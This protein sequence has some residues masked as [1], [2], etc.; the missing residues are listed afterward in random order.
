MNGIKRAALTIRSK[1]TGEAVIDVRISLTAIGIAIVAVRISLITAGIAIITA[2]L[3]F[4]CE[5]A[6][7]LDN[8]FSELG[9]LSFGNL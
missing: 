5:I 1:Y 9:R 6:T 2:N 7:M 3:Q 8:L 4:G